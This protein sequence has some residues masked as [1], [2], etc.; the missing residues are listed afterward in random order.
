VD[1]NAFLSRPGPRIV[2]GTE[3]LATLL[4]DPDPPPDPRWARAV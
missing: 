2:E 4:H 1:A 3:L